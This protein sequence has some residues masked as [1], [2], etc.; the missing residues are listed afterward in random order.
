MNLRTTAKKLPRVR[1]QSPRRCSL[2]LHFTSNT[3]RLA[4]GFGRIEWTL[5]PSRSGGSLPTYAVARV[6]SLTGLGLRPM[7]LDSAASRLFHC[8][9]SSRLR[10]LNESLLLQFETPPMAPSLCLTRTPC[11][12]LTP[13]PTY[14]CTAWRLLVPRSF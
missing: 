1:Q 13:A 3:S 2:S 7:R 14:G 6:F 11:L 8:L 10:L 9:S 4:A 12:P 5:P